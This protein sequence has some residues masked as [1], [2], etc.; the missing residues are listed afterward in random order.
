MMLFRVASAFEIWSHAVLVYSDPL[1]THLE[2]FFATQRHIEQRHVPGF[3]SAELWLFKT[4]TE[5]PDVRMF[6]EH[7]P[8]ALAR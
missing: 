1:P 8:L 3:G 5:Q 6:I 2:S 7:M 4:E